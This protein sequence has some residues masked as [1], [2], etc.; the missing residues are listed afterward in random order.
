MHVSEYAIEFLDLIRREPHLIKQFK[1]VIIDEFQDINQTQFEIIKEFYDRRCIITGVGD[2]AQNIYAFRGSSPKYMSWFQQQL[3][4]KTY[5]LTSNYRST[6]E[7]VDFSNQARP[8]QNG[9]LVMIA[10][11][12]LYGAKPALCHF[13]TVH[14]QNEAIASYIKDL[15]SFNVQP[16]KIAILSPTNAPLFLMEETLIKHEIKNIVLEKSGVFQRTRKDDHVCLSTIHKSKGL[17][18]D[19]V[20]VIGAIDTYLP[21]RTSPKEI[22]EA[23]R[24]FYVAL[25]RAKKSLSVCFTGSNSPTR[26][27]LDIRNTYY[28]AKSD[29]CSF[30]VTDYRRGSKIKSL[31]ELLKHFDGNDYKYLRET[32]LMPSESKTTKLYQPIKFAKFIHNEHLFQDFQTFAQLYLVRSISR[33][34][35]LDENKVDQTVV[36][37]LK[38]AV[39][40]AESYRVYRKYLAHLARNYQFI[41]TRMTPTAMKKALEDKM[42]PIDSSDMKVLHK[43]IAQINA[44]S[45][46]YFV[47]FEQIQVFP[48]PIKVPSR[49][50]S[51]IQNSL[52]QFSDFT[53]PT[54]DVLNALWDLTICYSIVRK[55]RARLLYHATTGLEVYTKHRGMFVGMVELF[56]KPFVLPFA[57]QVICRGFI[58]HV[59]HPVITG[60]YHLKCGSTLY[61]FTADGRDAT[62]S[63]T[64]LE[65]LTYK[66]VL[67]EQ[68]ELVEDI[69]VFDA[70][71]GV[72]RNIDVRNYDSNR[73]IQYMLQK[74][75]SL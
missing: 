35:G 33:W 66:A 4:T 34:L 1:H 69:A 23:R 30:P 37:I 25:T 13:K 72:I 10:K 63:S 21:F 45:E 5:S 39:V 24:L 54:S 6:Q 28:D 2:Q 62:E 19:V 71:G 73:L 3:T 36:K 40:D 46:R 43:L 8:L 7:L 16:E 55:K 27:M 42:D 57:G 20:F 70:L 41:N 17:E 65:L 49:F 29:I 47:P 22:E 9:A 31:N 14:K 18:W 26:F 53:K 51:R 64:I 15:I 75:A 59:K 50:N 67:E 32:G 68:R 61:H 60:E 74:E 12:Q 48:T 58:Q 56:I 44:K 52:I 38:G 11:S